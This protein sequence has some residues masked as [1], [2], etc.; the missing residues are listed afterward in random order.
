M[1]PLENIAITGNTFKNVKPTKAYVLAQVLPG[2][3]GTTPINTLTISGNTVWVT[4]NHPEFIETINTAHI[5]G[6]TVSGNQFNPQQNKL[7]QP[8]TGAQRP[9]TA[10]N[11]G[12]APLGKPNPTLAIASLGLICIASAL[13]VIT[14]RR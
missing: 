6:L 5:I 2:P 7:N 11:T 10:P 13:Y 1:L 9:V 4:G 12:A 3:Y 8:G 14:K